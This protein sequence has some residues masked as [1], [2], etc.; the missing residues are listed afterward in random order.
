M[1][2]ASEVR[3]LLER[4]K[5]KGLR[6]VVV[7]NADGEQQREPAPTPEPWFRGLP[8]WWAW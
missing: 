4:V 2:D 3:G 6:V 8:D 5:A 7:L 1:V